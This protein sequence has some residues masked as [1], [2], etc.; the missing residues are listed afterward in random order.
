[1][2]ISAKIKGVYCLLIKLNKDIC[3]KVGSIG[4]ISFKKGYYCYVGS[5]QNSLIA[6]VSRHLS[7]RKTI[8]WHIDYLLNN[9]NS[10]IKKVLYKVSGKKEECRIAGALAK[11][12][13]PV[14]GFGCSDCRCNSHLFML[15]SP[16]ALVSLKLKEL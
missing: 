6:R 11:K 3:I 2:T 13:I 10:S 16:D 12:A 15:D 14:V 5:A 7:S 1:M 8:R 4:K 9:R